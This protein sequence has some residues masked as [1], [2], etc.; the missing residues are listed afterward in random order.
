MRTKFGTLINVSKKGRF[1]E[2]IKFIPVIFYK[3]TSGSEPVRKWLWELEKE[4]R[5][6]IGTDIRT[7]QIDWPV[8]KPLV[9]PFGNGLWEIRSALENR[10]ARIFFVFKDGKIVLLHG[11]IKKTQ[12]TPPDGSKLALKRAKTLK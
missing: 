7:V 4:D 11:F 8:G 2:I 10:I 12:K 1:V 6:T 5:K 3:E 9:S